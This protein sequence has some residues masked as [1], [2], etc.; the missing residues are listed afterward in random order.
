MTDNSVFQSKLSFTFDI[1]HSF[2]SIH[3]MQFYDNHI[4]L[5]IYFNALIFYEF[6]T[7]SLTMR[8]G[9]TLPRS[10]QTRPNGEDPEWTNRVSG[11]RNYPW[12]QPQRDLA[13]EREAERETV[14]QISNMF[15]KELRKHK[16][17]C[18]G[19]CICVINFAHQKWTEED[20]RD[21]VEVC[22]VCT[23]FFPDAFRC[24][25]AE[26]HVCFTLLLS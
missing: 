6:K 7:V 20:E 23:A 2:N 13:S 18:T 21:E 16:H 26:R 12:S 15:C 4:I 3:T 14:K 5:Y 24:G 11:T 17:T 25:V 19:M 10:V 8:R 22:E 9:H 1:L